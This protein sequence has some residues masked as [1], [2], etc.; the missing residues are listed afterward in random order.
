[1]QKKGKVGRRVRFGGVMTRCDGIGPRRVAKGVE[2]HRSLKFASLSFVS[3]LKRLR[4]AFSVRLRRARIAR[5]A[6]LRRTLGLLRR[7]RWR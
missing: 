2:F 1:M 4:S 7:L 6:A 3:F 5:V